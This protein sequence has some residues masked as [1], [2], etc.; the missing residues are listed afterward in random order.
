[1]PTGL[2]ARPLC[3]LPAPGRGYHMG[4]RHLPP[5]ACSAPPLVLAAPRLSG[6]SA[7]RRAHHVVPSCR[8]LGW[9]ARSFSFFTPLVVVARP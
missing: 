6:R 3:P 7:R 5:A 2:G 9:I 4:W 1:M 8:A